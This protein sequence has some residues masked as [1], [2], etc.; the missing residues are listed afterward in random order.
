MKRAPIPPSSG[1]WRL[2]PV[3]LLL[4]GAC[5]SPHLGTAARLARIDAAMGASQAS[6]SKYL[7]YAME[8][9][10]GEWTHEIVVS[11]GAYAERRTRRSD[12]VGYA[13]GRDAAGAWLRIGEGEVIDESAG[14]WDQE[15]RTDAG[16]YGLGF[17]HP[18]RGDEATYMGRIAGGWE[19]AFRPA[20]GRTITLAVDHA[21]EPWAFDVVDDFGR[22][23][24]C[25]GLGWARGAVGPV[26][27]AWSCASNDR[28]G[29]AGAVLEAHYQMEAE[30]PLDGAAPAWAEPGAQRIS[31]PPLAR[32]VEIPFPD[33]RRIFVPV[34]FGDGAPVSM[35]LDTG[36][37]FT[38]VSARAAARL[39]VVPTGE[40]RLHI[41]PPWLPRTHLWIGIVEK[42][43]V[44][45][46]TLYGE[47][48]L[49]AESQDFG[50]QVGL[51]GRSTLRRFIVD[52]DSPAAT[53]RFWPRAGFKPDPEGRA[54]ALHGSEMPM[55]DGA[56][57]HVDRGHIGL[58]TG[59]PDDIVVYSPAMAMYHRRQ[60]GSDVALGGPDST[61]SPD[62]TT[63]LD[64][65]D[66]GPFPFPRMDGI[67]RD[68]DQ[69][70]LGPGIALAGMG[71]MRYFRVAF[72]LRGEQ[73]LVSP[74]DGY[75][76]LRR[77]GMDVE[78]GD[79]PT[80]DRVIAG[81]PA[82]AAGVKRGDVILAV[83][84]DFGAHAS[85]RA[86]R[87]AL[88]RGP[89]HPFTIWVERRGTP[90]RLELA[91]DDAEDLDGAEGGEA[92][93]TLRTLRRAAAGLK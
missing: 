43:R 59:M 85:T 89:R 68:R 27:A 37:F 69:R 30:E 2:A 54:L 17:A 61:R 49:V 11:P 87:R 75:R 28:F 34:R 23:V 38:I 83:D 32:P 57:T 35:I 65:V 18:A 22:L 63:P 92:L 55:I 14:L 6:R 45:A 64:G 79:G 25:D 42:M 24:S 36:A 70:F 20:G 29:V 91:L 13:F 31:P 5:A 66:F 8:S 52:V 41:D 39:G 88:G 81:G 93:V 26:L 1:L 48:V 3:L 19:L 21:S 72:D 60:P 46:A 62:Y 80:V 9:D 51:L 74:G 10:A 40:V 15:A 90:R 33:P 76:T 82:D 16:L 12:G 47:R 84:H 86:A 73:L 44:G 7:R 77:A 78:D 58:D 71:L 67:G 50:D 56:V 4:L 53:L